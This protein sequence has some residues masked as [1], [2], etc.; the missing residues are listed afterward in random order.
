MDDSQ[1]KAPRKADRNNSSKQIFDNFQ[2]NDEIGL[3]IDTEKQEPDGNF[4]RFNEGIQLENI[5]N[6]EKP[7]KNKKK[8]T[9]LALFSG[10]DKLSS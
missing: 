6:D 8:P 4:N 10:R 7:I 1:K 3:Q 2:H 9:K 5:Y